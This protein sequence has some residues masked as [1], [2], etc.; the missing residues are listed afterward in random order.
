MSQSMNTTTTLATIRSATRAPPERRLA[1][2][3][4]PA[5]SNVY[6][7]IPAPKSNPIHRVTK[8]NP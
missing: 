6:P 3:N 8:P 1:S 4:S 2:S 5:A 7:A